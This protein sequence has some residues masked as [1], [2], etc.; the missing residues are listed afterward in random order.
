VA[1]ARAKLSLPLANLVAARATSNTRRSL[2]RLKINDEKGKTQNQDYVDPATEGQEMQTACRCWSVR[3]GRRNFVQAVAQFPAG[4]GAGLQS[5]L[6]YC[7]M[8]FTH[9][10]L[11]LAVRHTANG[12]AGL[13]F[14]DCLLASFK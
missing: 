13:R 9:H 8:R 1:T 7:F 14:R 5:L 3:R 12:Q 6:S 11:H 4:G 10:R 2:S